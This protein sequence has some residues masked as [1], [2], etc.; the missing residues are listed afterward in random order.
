MGKIIV[1]EDNTLFAEIGQIWLAGMLPSEFFLMQKC[2]KRHKG[3]SDGQ[4]T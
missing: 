1:L 3:G 2:P 4:R